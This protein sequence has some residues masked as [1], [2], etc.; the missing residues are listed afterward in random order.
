MAE[1]YKFDVLVSTQLPVADEYKSATKNVLVH[2]EIIVK[3]NDFEITGDTFNLTNGYT[4]NTRV[5]TSFSAVGAH[6][7]S[8]F[9]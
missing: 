8:D 6:T 3:E 2:I 5:N 7:T 1:S 4:T 9:R